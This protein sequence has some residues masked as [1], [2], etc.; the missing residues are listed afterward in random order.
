MISDNRQLDFKK[1]FVFWYPLA[2][3]WLMMA[4]ENPFLA[5]IIAR[6]GDAKFNLAAFGV[7]Y[8][9]ALIIEAPIIMLMA[10]ST[11]LVKDADSLDKLRRFAFT[12]NGSIT[13]LMVILVIPPLFF[14]LTQDL[15]GLPERV[16]QLTHRSLLEQGFGRFFRLCAFGQ[17]TVL[18]ATVS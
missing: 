17:G 12:L 1:I 2:A 18:S 14:P 7:A 13:V 16:A 9:F 4:V 8:S 10:A 5:A 6:L 11:V 3:T 15:I